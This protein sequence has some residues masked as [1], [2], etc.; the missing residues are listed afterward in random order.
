MTA[1]AID[2]EYYIA[3]DNLEV[4]T[5]GDYAGLPN[6]NYGRLTFLFAHPNE[7]DPSTNH[8]H[9]IG[10]YS[11]TGPVDNPTVISTNSNNRIPEIYT[12]ALPLRL[13]PGTEIYAGKLVSQ[14]TGEEYSRLNMASVQALSGF[15]SDS[16]E[17]FLF[18][19]SSD[20][21]S[22]PITGAVV[23]LQLVSITP[24]LHIADDSGNRV[25][26]RQARHQ[27]G[28]GN[29]L[30]FF[31]TF[32]TKE[33][34]PAG[35]YSVTLKLVDVRTDGAPLD[36]SGRFTLDFRVS[37]LGDLDGD[38]DVDW[39][40]VIILLEALNAPATAPHDPRDLNQDGTI[41]F[42]DARLVFGLL[43]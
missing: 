25:F 10:A 15:P 17:G 32:W 21:W 4:L 14:D 39:D 6:P 36:D 16:P 11:Y 8:F 3:I 18:H 22:A 24:R 28:E 26:A 12:G 27:L 1:Q 5:S 23:A 20:R 37:K 41:D 43:S 2:T 35:T 29:S 33:G 19:S 38:N 31:P 7:E 34:V 30:V 13:L 40:D 42:E 9:S